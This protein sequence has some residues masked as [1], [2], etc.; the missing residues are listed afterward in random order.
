MQYT[1]AWHMFRSLSSPFHPPPASQWVA[2]LQR[3]S[4]MLT[5]WVNYL[6]IAV[7]RFFSQFAF[8]F[9]SKRMH[10]DSWKCRKW[11]MHGKKSNETIP[12]NTIK[13]CEK[14]RLYCIAYKSGS[15][16]RKIAWKLDCVCVFFFF[17]WKLNCQSKRVQ[18]DEKWC[19]ERWNN[20]KKEEV[21]NQ[22]RS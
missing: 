14:Y 7:V 5:V 2:Y 13:L 20:Y 17:S 18:K 10:F 3:T 8:S 1:T 15:C 19:R 21:I 6:S 9:G 11:K 22:F 12:P 16:S 4:S